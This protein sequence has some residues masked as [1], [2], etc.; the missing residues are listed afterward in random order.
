MNPLTIA[1]AGREDVDPLLV[2][3]H[4]IGNAKLSP[5]PFAQA[6]K[7]KLTHASLPEFLFVQEHG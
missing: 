6:S 2:D 3:R 1:G 4:P 7:C 5:D